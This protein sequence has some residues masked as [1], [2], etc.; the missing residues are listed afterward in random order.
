VVFTVPQIAGIRCFQCAT[1]SRGEGAA[2][3]GEI[4]YGTGQLIAEPALGSDISHIVMAS[5]KISIGLLELGTGGVPHS[6]GNLVATALAKGYQ[7]VIL[8]T[9]PGYDFF[10]RLFGETAGQHGYQSIWMSVAGNPECP[11]CGVQPLA[12]GEFVTSGPDLAALHPVPTPVAD[13]GQAAAA[14]D[15]DAS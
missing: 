11:T 2:S 15:E 1:A 7:Y 9:V 6:A 5:V 12:I 3:Q 14:D 4:N 10:P 8:S 13:E